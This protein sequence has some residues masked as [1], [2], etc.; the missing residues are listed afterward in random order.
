MVIAPKPEYRGRAWK[1]EIRL[2]AALETSMS[3]HRYPETSLLPAGQHITQ[4]TARD[5]AQH[6]L[7]RPVRYANSDIDQRQSPLSSPARLLLYSL[8]V[9]ADTD[10]RSPSERFTSRE[11]G[12]PSDPITRSQTGQP[13]FDQAR[14]HLPRGIGS[15]TMDLKEESQ[16]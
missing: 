15:G 12:D 2:R 7:L 13:L 3:G 6:T 5:A 10:R 1:A 9:N 14:G 11:S 16:L 8:P 4:T